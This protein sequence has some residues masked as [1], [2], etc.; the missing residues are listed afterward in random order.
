M[1]FCEATSDEVKAACELAQHVFEEYSQMSDADRSSFLVRIAE[2]LQRHKEEIGEV[3]CAESGLSMDR[4][5]G[6][7][8]RT[9]RQLFNFSN[10]LKSGAW[11]NASIDTANVN[12]Q[13][14]KP[15]L[16]K[17][18]VPLGPVVVF[19]ASNFPLA[20]ST[21]GGDTAAAL[22][23]G[24]PVIVKAHALHAETSDIVA[25]LVIQAAQETGMP[26]GVFSHLHSRSFRVGQELIQHPHVKAVGFTGSHAG[27]RALFDLANSRKEPIP[28]FAE[29]G[30]VNPV[31]VFP[32]LLKDKIKKEQ[33][34]EMLANSMI[35]GMGQF[36][37]NPGLIFV[38]DNSDSAEFI[39]LLSKKFLNKET[40]TML[41]VSI[42]ERFDQG[43]VKMERQGVELNQS[44]QVHAN[45]SVNQALGVIKGSQFIQNSEFQEEVFGPF[46][47]IVRCTDLDEMMG[48][49]K[50]LNGQLTATIIA[51]DSEIK[52]EQ[53]LLFQLKNKVGRIIF[54][55]VPTGVDISPSM[56]HGGPYPATTDSRFSAVGIDSF[57][58]FVRPVAFQDCPD[59][60]LPTELKNRNEKG[61]LR[62]VDDEWTTDDVNF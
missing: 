60:F 43:K 6:E 62:R 37:T 22:A 33:S 47:L 34:A 18:S 23:V 40:S 44:T 7:M 53:K 10:E 17:I 56:H 3:Y 51:L 39:D 13:P 21:I 41:H 5:E 16:R 31:F 24:C 20:Y 2:L 9:I 48:C 46:T 19:G 57:Q 28:V 1:K 29:M 30:S 38:I 12:Q 42:K 50:A 14:A 27:G 32:E 59:E 26:N 11:R 15:D 4:F 36:C 49:C 54:N 25:T 52:A 61:I 45:Q 8:L 58:R 55:G 35:S